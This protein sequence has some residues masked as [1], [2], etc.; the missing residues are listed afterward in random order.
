M[1]FQIFG[2]SDLG[3]SG[4]GCSVEGADAALRLHGSGALGSQPVR[5]STWFGRKQTKQKSLRDLMRFVIFVVFVKTW[6]GVI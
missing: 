2:F 1:A 6:N 4:L 5:T 3:R